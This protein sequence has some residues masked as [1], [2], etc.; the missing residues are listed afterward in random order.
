MN[1]YIL[2]IY[3]DS[4]HKAKNLD[5]LRK[6]LVNYYDN[7]KRKIV[8]VYVKTNTGKR[9]VGIFAKELGLPVWYA[10]YENLHN[11]RVIEENTGKLY[12]ESVSEVMKSSMREWMGDARP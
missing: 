8:E 6:W 11:S 7:S 3:E 9:F 1:T 12:S 2:R 10:T 5:Y 4:E